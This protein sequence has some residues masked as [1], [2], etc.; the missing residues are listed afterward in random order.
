MNLARLKVAHKLSRDF[1]AFGNLL[2]SQ[3]LLLPDRESLL[4]CKKKIHAT[5]KFSIS[6]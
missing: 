4:A 1:G 2:M 5:V 3:S 6:Y